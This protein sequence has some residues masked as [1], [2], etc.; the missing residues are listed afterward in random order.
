MLSKNEAAL[1]S[2]LEQDPFRSQQDLAD[3]LG[4]PRSTVANLISGLVTKKY[5]LGRAYVLNQQADVICIGGMNVD[6]KYVLAGDFK[7]KTSNPVSSS[8]SLGGVARNIAE[9]LGRL[10]ETVTLLSVAGRD[11]DYDWVKLRTEAHVNLQQV[12]QLEG[13]VT[14]SYTAI[15][16]GD[17][18]MQLGLADMS[19]CDRMT[20]DWLKG[21]QSLLRATRLVVADLNLPL[22]TVDALIKQAEKEGLELV[23]IP[24]SAPKMDRLPQDLKGVT[25]L[26]VNQD[27]SEAYF[28]C[29]VTSEEDFTGLADQWLA[30]GVQQVLITRGKASSYYANQ[31]GERAWFQPPVVDQVVDVT[32]A[33]DS[34]S[35]GLIHAH[36][37]GL[38]PAQAVAYGLT[39]AYHTIQTPATVRLDLSAQQLEQDYK[40]LK[41]KGA[42]K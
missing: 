11:H 37:Q 22:E 14:S 9:N 31:A 18:E 10:G 38:S 32:G 27:E 21:Y 5:L 30:R 26:V 13:E 23:I 34:F 39:N 7:P 1:L 17:G 24:V 12:T 15:L 6:R 19:I 35:A 41:A 16:D 28:D 33:G 20:P 2:L 29:Q 36:L 25:W 40:K 3:Q 8:L 4:L 42:L